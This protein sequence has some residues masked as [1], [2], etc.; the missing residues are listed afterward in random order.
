MN[1]YLNLTLCVMC[2]NSEVEHA[3]ARPHATLTISNISFADTSQRLGRNAEGMPVSVSPNMDTSGFESVE[4]AEE[5]TKRAGLIDYLTVNP[6]WDRNTVYLCHS[7]YIEASQVCDVGYD[8]DPV[9]QPTVSCAFDASNVDSLR[10]SFAMKLETVRVGGYGNYAIRNLISVVKNLR[11]AELGFPHSVSDLRDS[12]TMEELFP[13][14]QTILDTVK[15]LTF[16]DNSLAD[17][18]LSR[19][20]LESHLLTGYDTRCA[21]HE[22][23]I[24]CESCSDWMSSDEAHWVQANYDEVSLCSGC[25]AS[26]AHYCDACDRYEMDDYECEDGYSG[27]IKDYGYK[28][29]P[30][31]FYKANPELSGQAFGSAPNRNL[32]MGMELEVEARGVASPDEL[33]EL[34]E[35]KW[36]DKAYFKHDGSL[37]N[38]V[39]IVTH[40][41]DLATFMELDWSALRDVASQGGRSWDTSSCGLHIH[42][43]RSALHGNTHI[44]LL[45]Q[46]FAANERE[47]KS[48]VGRDSSYAS[49]GSEFKGV[50]K[51]AKKDS[52]DGNR[53]LAINYNN[54]HTIEMRVFKGSLKVERVKAMLQFAHATFTYA[55]SLTANNVLSSSKDWEDVITNGALSWKS[56]KDFCFNNASEYW[57]LCSHLTGG[58]VRDPEYQNNNTEQLV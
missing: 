3:F 53:Y 47:I 18:Q 28:P 32:F 21:R 46:F 39:E 22:D 34:V 43:S 55:G 35:A 49:F 57:E 41:M 42:L 27:I 6:V 2:G 20:R 48:L 52:R 10:R 25:Y 26:N 9:I 15:L 4:T 38:G 37:N 58:N 14:Y 56:F 33:A 29:E 54:R 11:N 5:Y 12:I 30:I 8:C 45:G 31:F 51:H 19:V 13:D 7:C 17:L 23:W 36:G 50:V 24:T 44:W 1:E 40:P 16:T